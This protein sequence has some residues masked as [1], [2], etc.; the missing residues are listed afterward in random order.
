MAHHVV[1]LLNWTSTKAVK[2]N[3]PYE[4]AFG[5]KPDLSKVHEWSEKVWVH[6]EK[7]NK[8]GGRVRDGHWVGIDD[9]SK[10]VCISWPDKQNIMVEWNVYYDKTG[11]ISFSF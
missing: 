4:T 6:V 1:W 10:G 2:G 11:A 3:T 8:L 5:K 7:G 9:T